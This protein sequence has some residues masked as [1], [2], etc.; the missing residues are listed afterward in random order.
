MRSEEV[1]DEKK[2]EEKQAGSLCVFQSMAS[3]SPVHQGQVPFEGGKGTRHGRK[4]VTK[5][6][7]TGRVQ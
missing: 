1:D 7:G 4:T 6:G 2:K 5:A 3:F